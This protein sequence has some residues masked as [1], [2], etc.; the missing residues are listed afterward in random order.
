MSRKYRFVSFYSY[1]H[2][3]FAFHYQGYYSYWLPLLKDSQSVYHSFNLAINEIVSIEP[4]VGIKAPILEVLKLC[5]PLII[6]PKIES[7]P[8]SLSV[9]WILSILYG[10]NSMV[11]KFTIFTHSLKWNFTKISKSLCSKGK[12]IHI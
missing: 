1:S 11:T 9:K 7:L 5:T 10:L 12:L 2:V 6:K 8:L 3:L 4:L